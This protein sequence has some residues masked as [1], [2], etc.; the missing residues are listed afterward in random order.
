MKPD[1]HVGCFFIGD[2]LVLTE[3]L[4]LVVRHSSVAALSV[5]HDELSDKPVEQAGNTRSADGAIVLNED[6][7]ATTDS[8]YVAKI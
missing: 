1:K 6:G 5:E 3:L 2:Q 4:E 8:G 7:R